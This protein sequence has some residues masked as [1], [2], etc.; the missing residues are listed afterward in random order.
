MSARASVLRRLRSRR[1]ES[2]AIAL[3]AALLSVVLLV[4]AAFTIDIG[5]AWARRKELQL[6]AD[7]AAL[8]AAESLP[9]HDDAGKTKVARAAAWYIACHRVPGQ[10]TLTPI[11]ACPS[12]SSAPS[13]ELDAFTATLLASG[14]VSFPDSNQ[15][16]VTAPPAQVD[17]SF[18]KLTGADGS[19]QQKQAS[20]RVSS[21]G[22]IEPFG[23]S[24][25]CLL[26]V[27]DNLPSSLGSSLSGVL[28]L[29]YLAP[30]PL[31][32]DTTQT[33]W[34]TNLPTS[35]SLRVDAITPTQVDQGIGASFA[36]TGT[37]WGTSSSVK[38]SFALG[39]LNDADLTKWKSVD[40]PVLPADLSVAGQTSTAVGVLPATVVS[41]AGN[42]HVKVATADAAGNWV[43]SH[44]DVV[45]TVTVPDVTA[46]MLGCGRIL[47][48]P[49]NFQDGTPT[50]LRR[51]MQL[52]LDH[53]VTKHPSL[54]TL[55]PPDT[56]VGGVLS[57]LGGPDGLFQCNDTSPNVKDTGGNL[58]NGLVPNCM[59]LAQGS[60]TY[61]EF[62]EG[63][64]GAPT[65]VTLPDGTS[66][67]VAGRL[68]CTAERPCRSDR[69]FSISGLPGRTF[70]DD[71][72][73]DF[74]TSSSLLSA[75]MFFNLSSY[76]DDGIPAVT[77]NGALKPEI[78]GSA[79]FFWVPV[80][81]T[82]LVPVANANDAGAYPVLT[83]RPVFVTAQESTGVP[84]VD[85]VLD[86]VD[87][88]VKTLLNIDSTD[89]HGVLMQGSTLRALRFLTIEPSALPPVSSSYAG[90]TSDYLGVGPKIIRLVK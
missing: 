73:S 9:V 49:R 27:A 17:Y 12:S 75:P 63:M 13:A 90:P 22:S 66:K 11:P 85:M 80:L 62:T 61:D 48:S 18:G 6:Q 23:L 78:Y 83:F 72:F 57:A 7:G 74:V 81:S 40:V 88:W 31:T 16:S 41:N 10:E 44:D 89:D 50:N 28:P 4:V 65:T 35:N 45:L 52:G 39:D 84:Q 14:D 3:I 36:L 54:L 38:V 37:G 43:W 53:L 24:L 34:K 56:S 70:N 2:G 8:F 82:P 64:L 26:T 55:N 19:V 76:L 86:L 71:H 58:V 32:K 33:R 21:P 1:E 79:R 60:S 30:G 87:T 5:D 42:W 15:V 68:V 51:N 46:D 47:K 29:N 59:V 20:A 25:N 69:Q 67:S 77:P